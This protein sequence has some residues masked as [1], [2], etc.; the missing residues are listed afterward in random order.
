MLKKLNPRKN[1]F[2]IINLINFY[3]FAQM[4]IDESRVPNPLKQLETSF[5]PIPKS[6]VKSFIYI[7]DKDTVSKSFFD[8]KGNE[9]TTISYE[10]NKPYYKVTNNYSG[11]LKTET[12]FF[13]KNIL[14]SIT[15]YKYDAK[16]NVIEWKV[17]KCIYEKNS[18]TPK[19]VNDIHTVFEYD[20]N[21]RVIKRFSIDSQNIK[22][23]SHENIFDSSNKLIEKKEIQWKEKYDYENDLLI[24]KSKIFNNENSIYSYS[25]YN[26]NN[27]KLLI[28]SND[29]FYT[30][31][32]SY[33]SLK[34]KKINYIYK[35]DNTT[36][37]ID[38][39]YKDDLLSKVLIS[40]NCLYSKPEFIFKSDYL[41]FSWKKNELNNLQMEFI[42]DEYKNIIEI[43]YFIK[44]IYKYSKLFK[45]SYY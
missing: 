43:K 35:K 11:E 7:V 37:D 42:Y 32:F 44:D 23:L 1:I 31:K 27:E 39:I 19:F 20:K 14:Q 4:P 34:L 15:T 10:S 25:D 45:Y 9:L 16:K 41:A 29:N 28:E 2:L 38:L 22:T 36:Q 3:A 24:K 26:Y 33:D 6:P 5:Y 40:T 21:N 8:K 30:S 17:I 13:I 12:S 18:S